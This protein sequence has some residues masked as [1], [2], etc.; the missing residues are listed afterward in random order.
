MRNPM[1]AFRYGYNAAKAVAKAAQ[2][3]APAGAGFIRLSEL[4]PC[5][6]KAPISEKEMAVIM[7]GGAE[8]Y[9]LKKRRA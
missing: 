8:D 7:F 9:E 2:A 5:F 1:I 3:A 4:P 6:R